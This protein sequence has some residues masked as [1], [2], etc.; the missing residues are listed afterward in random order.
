MNTTH[1]F[2]DAYEIAGDGRWPWS[3]VHIA[4]L[5]ATEREDNRASYSVTH[6]TARLGL[7]RWLKQRTNPT[8]GDFIED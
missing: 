6:R 2:P 1:D 4:D 8:V 7:R 3:R 5:V